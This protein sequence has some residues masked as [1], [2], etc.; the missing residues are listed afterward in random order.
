MQRHRNIEINLG[1]SESEANVVCVT[2][3]NKYDERQARCWL[4]V[5]IK[6]NG[7]AEA[8]LDSLGRDAAT[9]RTRRCPM[10][11]HDDLVP[12]PE[13]AGLAEGQS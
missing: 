2:L 10:D 4:R 6:P 1:Q 11:W 5:W 13:S 8:I 12:K 3:N 9:D 7:R